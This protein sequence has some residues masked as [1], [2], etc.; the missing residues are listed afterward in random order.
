V[1]VS[2]YQRSGEVPE[3]LAAA[4]ADDRDATAAVEDLEHDRDASASVPAVRLALRRRAVLDLAREERAAALELAEHVAP[5]RRVRL[6][7]L[8]AAALPRVLVAT[9][10]HAGAH[11]RKRLDRPDVR[12]PFEELAIDP[13]QALELGHVVR[14]E[15]APEHELLRR[16]NR[17]DRVDLQEAEPVDRLEDR[18]R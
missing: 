13:E 18:A 10:A 4:A 9:A 12:V 7:E 14:A 8:V 6:Q 5:E 1:C 2:G 11:E 17:R 3:A 16:C 15:P